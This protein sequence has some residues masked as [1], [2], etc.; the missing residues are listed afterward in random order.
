MA[1]SIAAVLDQSK[2]PMGIHDVVAE[3]YDGLSSEDYKRAKTALTN[4]LSAGRSQG[5]WKSTGRGLYIS[6]LA[7]TA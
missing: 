2:K 7:P 6:S 5:R 3:L 4:L 1:D